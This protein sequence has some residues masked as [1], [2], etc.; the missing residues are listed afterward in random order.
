MC[1]SRIN[2]GGDVD[3]A[4]G[5]GYTPLLMAAKEGHVA[6]V[7]FLAGLYATAHQR[8]AADVAMRSKKGLSALRLAQMYGHTDVEVRFTY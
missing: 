7:R 1:H 5:A 3:A 2:R 4:D 6:I 8:T